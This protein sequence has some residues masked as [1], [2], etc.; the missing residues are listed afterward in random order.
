MCLQGGEIGHSIDFCEFLLTIC[1]DRG[2]GGE[3]AQKEE[4]HGAEN[5]YDLAAQNQAFEKFGLHEV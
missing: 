5:E 3:Q 1:N 4:E 2:S